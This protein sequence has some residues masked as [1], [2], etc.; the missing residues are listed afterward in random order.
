MG[1][2]KDSTAKNSEKREVV[3][4]AA[5]DVFARY[6]FRRTVMNDIAQ[7][8]GISR[9]ALYLMFENKEALFRELA[10]FRQNQGIDLAISTLSENAAITERI[11]AAILAYERLFYEP[12]AESPHGAELV[13]ISISTAADLM[14]KGQERLDKALAQALEEASEN[15]EVDFTG[16]SMQPIAFV[17]LLMSSVGGLKKHASSIKVMR[18]QISELVSIFTKAISVASG[19]LN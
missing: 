18:R 5:Y 1:K 13:D 3:L 7:A 12:V 15:G 9:P 11:T 10:S 14:M 19:N 6:G 2:L 8:A 16:L 4:E 17:R